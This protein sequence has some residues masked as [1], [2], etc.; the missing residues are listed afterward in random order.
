MEEKKIRSQRIYEGKVIQVRVDEVEIEKKKFLREVVE[1]PGGVAVLAM[2]EDGL[3]P[4]VWQYRYG[5]K[6]EMLEL[7][8]GKLE[9]GENP[10]AA[11]QRELQ[12]ETG[13]Q[14]ENWIY[15][16]EFIPTGAY[17]EEKIQM[18]Y[19]DNLTFVGQCFDED[20]QIKNSEYTLDEL[21]EM[22]LNQQIIDGKTIAM[23]L[24]VKFM[25]EKNLLKI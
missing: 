16:G 5:Q 11:I 12:E 7:P 3:I 19:A 20:E 1:H 15:L 14:A 4:C 21:T 6:K 24:K 18:F 17:L 8:A 25:I 10:V 22:I 9:R 13:Y 23:V 2:K